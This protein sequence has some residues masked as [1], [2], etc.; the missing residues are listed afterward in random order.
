MGNF[1]GDPK[2]P[3]EF[4]DDQEPRSAVH[5]TSVGKRYPLGQGLFAPLTPCHKLLGLI[6]LYQ[7]EDPVRKVFPGVIEL[8]C[9]AVTPDVL[10]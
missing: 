5:S 3:A 2:A 8:L 9:P 10:I 6:P 4:W 7:F 1:S